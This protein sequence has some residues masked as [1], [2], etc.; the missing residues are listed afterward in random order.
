MPKPTASSIEPAANPGSSELYSF[1]GRSSYT[2]SN[3]NPN[4]LDTAFEALKKFDYGSDLNALNPIEDAIVAA[5]D[6]PDARRELENRIV[7]NLQGELSRDAQEYLCRKLAAIGT[8]AS[9]PRLSELLVNKDVSHMARFALERIPAPEAAQA[10]R[11]TLPKVS[12]NQKIGVISSIGARRDTAAVAPLASLL[13]DADAS[14]AR[15]SAMALGTIGTTES[16]A[17]LQSALKGAAGAAGG[18]GVGAF[19]DTSVIRA[20]R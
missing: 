13:G 9:V 8:A 3:G 16:A 2:P 4:M 10:L 7:A 12:G 11:D 5:H 17:A 18:S 19:S 14:V 15:A 20:A 6:K 1:F